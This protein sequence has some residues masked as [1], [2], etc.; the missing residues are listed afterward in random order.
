M[1]LLEDELLGFCF[2]DL[3]DSD[4]LCSSFSRFSEVAMIVPQKV[5]EAFVGG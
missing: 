4:G 3:P 1:S 2:S 5:G